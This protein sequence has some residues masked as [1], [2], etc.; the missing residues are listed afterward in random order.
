MYAHRLDKLL[1]QAFDRWLESMAEA[2][3][4]VWLHL[5]T[6]HDPY[7]E[8][9]RPANAPAPPEDLSDQ[10][11]GEVRAADRMVGEIVRSIEEHVGFERAKIIFT[12]DHGEAFGEHG[13][14]EHGHTLHREVTH[15]PLIAVANELPAGR[16]VRAS[17]PSVDIL[18]T[19]LELSG[20]APEEPSSIEGTSLL[21]AIDGEAR[22]RP[23]YAE[24]MLYGTTERSLIDGGYKL[25]FD[26]EGERYALYDLARDPGETNDLSETDAD[27]ANRM[28]AALT[29]HHSRLRDRY[30]TRRASRGGGGPSDEERRRM[31][32]ALRALGYG[33]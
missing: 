5:L 1:V 9:P 10:Y 2:G 6:P 32:E 29:D 13:M 20:V 12:S 24:G 18:P 25:M 22:D 8:Y 3:I 15:V 14:T 27:R 19:F 26:A 16:V 31:E 23:V 21:S 7:L 30:R 33:E 11:D 17:V 28:K 4:F